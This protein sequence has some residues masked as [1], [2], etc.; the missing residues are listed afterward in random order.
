MGLGFELHNAGAQLSA[1]RSQ[2]GRVYQH[3]IS[4]DAV[5]TLTGLNF[6]IVNKQQL[7]IGLQHRPK[8]AVHGQ[9]LLGVFAGVLAGFGNIDLVELDLAGTFAAQ[10]FKA[11]AAAAQV[12]LSQAG[13]A[14]R[15]V[16]FQ[17]IALQ[18]GVVAIALHLDTVVGKYMAVVFDVL[19]Q[20]GPG[21]VL[22][23]GLEPRQHL[24]QRQLCGRAR[25]VVRQRNVSGCSGFHAQ[26][27]P[28]YPG[29]HRI[30]R[31]RLRVHGH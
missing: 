7:G 19:A 24:G 1:L 10:V 27:Q 29:L 3:A 6:Q 11:D 16:H 23:P 30:D 28:H 5:Q 22:Q 21:R 9:G 31:G 17:H 13:Q 25:V 12:A 26:A 18:H 8:Q 2:H 20:L 4:F 15:L 14:M